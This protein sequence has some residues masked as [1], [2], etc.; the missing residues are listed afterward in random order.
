M[1]RT[2][3]LTVIA[4]AVAS[5][6]LSK[7]YLEQLIANRMEE[8]RF[9]EEPLPSAE[10]LGQSK[11]V[12]YPAQLGQSIDDGRLTII[13][14]LDWSIHATSTVWLAKME[15]TVEYQEKPR[16]VAVKILASKPPA[17]DATSKRATPMSAGRLE[18]A[19]LKKISSAD[20]TH[21]G[22]THLSEF[23][24]SF[25]FAGHLCFTLEVPCGSIHALRYP[26]PP[27]HDHHEDARKT[28]RVPL[29]VAKRAVR[30]VLLA[31]VYLHDVCGIIHTDIRDE[32][33]VFR[34]KSVARLVADTLVDQPSASYRGAYNYPD[35]FLD[36]GNLS[37]V[38]VKSQPL[39]VP[40]LNVLDD[41]HFV[42]TE[43]SHAEWKDSRSKET[44]MQEPI[45]PRGL[46]APEV[47]V[48][49][50][51]TTPVDIWNFGSLIWEWIVGYRLASP[52]DSTDRSFLATIIELLGPFDVN[53]LMRCHCANVLFNLEDGSLLEENFMYNSSGVSLAIS[54]STSPTTP[55]DMYLEPQSEAA[56]EMRTQTS[57]PSEAEEALG[58]LRRSLKQDPEERSSAKQLLDDP[59][60][61][62]NA[63]P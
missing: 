36:S 22:H 38:P 19:L 2:D 23:I 17:A 3:P 43:F 41:V 57:N 33:I 37:G 42:L 40:D 15:Y 6:Q 45:Q 50:P 11:L 16:L 39:P 44:F 18:R 9:P 7:D 49:G 47:Y 21:P 62:V 34:P 58:F 14:K 60:L 1:G 29:L 26:G 54:P 20:S 13:R 61:A 46:R 12:Y 32:N 35:I 28:P 30:H 53:F 55:L 31:L 51:W 52:Y 56:V 24:D 5:G 8:F 25:E 48:G 27:S 59:W 10:Y 63:K 4:D